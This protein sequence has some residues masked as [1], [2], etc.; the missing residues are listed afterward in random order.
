MSPPLELASCVKINVAALL[1]VYNDKSAGAVGKDGLLP[2]LELT[3]DPMLGK[4][5]IRI[6]IMRP[7]LSDGQP[8][9]WD[10]GQLN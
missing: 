9:G 1:G 8:E 10:C 3:I 5:R 4:T 7:L 2:A 6:M